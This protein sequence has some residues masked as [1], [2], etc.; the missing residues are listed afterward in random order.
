MPI[1][2]LARFPYLLPTKNPLTNLIITATRKKLLHAGVNS[3]LIA[4]RQAY[5][6]PS[7]RQTIRGLRIICRKTT[8]KAYQ[9]PDPP[10]LI[11]ARTQ[12]TAPFEVTGVDFMAA[13]Y[14]QD[15]TSENK[16]YV[17]LFT[18]GVNR[19]IH[20][21]IVTDLTVETFLQ[22]FRRFSSHKSLPKVM[23]SDNASTYL[24][25]AEELTKIFRETQLSEALHRMGVTW[26]FVP[27][28]APWFRGFWE[29]L[30]SL[31]KTTLK[32]VLRRTFVNLVTFQTIIM[33]VYRS[34]YQRSTAHICLHGYN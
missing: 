12:K 16:V 9:V 6:I 32:K 17:C 25:A 8:G 10:P 29:R 33:E 13:L 11:K 14:I 5:W 22:A 34:P 23:M 27:K 21:E 4:I 3:T 1:S 30:I 31:T 15:G 20:L 19:A 7:A 26:R 2:E 18:C 28:R 24:A